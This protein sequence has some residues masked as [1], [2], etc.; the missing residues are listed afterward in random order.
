MTA[1]APAVS[2]STDAPATQSP[3]WADAVIYQIYP[4][5]FADGN[6]DGMGDL[7]GVRS[8]LPYLR[9]LGVDAIWLSPFYVSPQA[10]AGYDVADYRDVDPLFGTLADFDSMLAEAHESGM[11]VIVDLVPNHTSDEH[12]WFKAAK[13]AAIGSPERDRYI[14][15][16]GKGPAGEL[17][18]NNWQSIFGGNAWTRLDDGQWYLHLFDTKQP[19]L[20][21]DN[22]EVRAEMVS[23]LRFWLDR[24][25][26]G[27]RIDVAHGMV[28]AEG[29]PDW[30]EQARMI[31]GGHSDQAADSDSAST[32]TTPPYFDQ[33]GVH[34]IYREWNKVLAQYDGD[35]ML[36]AEAWVEPAE[37]LFRYVRHDEMQQAFN[38]DFL[39]AGWDAAQLTSSITESLAEAGKVGAPSTWVMS[40]HDTVRHTSRFGLED[41]TQFPKGLGSQHEQPDE[42]LG[43][44]RGRAAALVMLGLPGSAYLYQGDELG[45]PEHTTLP[46]GVREDPT[47]ARTSGSEIGRDGCRVPLPWVAEAPG[48]GFGVYDA[49]SAPGAAPWLPQPTSFAGYAADQQ[50][51]VDG[52][53]FELYRSALGLRR[54]HGLGTG[55]LEW[56]PLN[57]PQEGVLSYRNG[58]VLVFANMG[59]ETIDLPNDHRV[60]LASGEASVDGGRLTANASVWLVAAESAS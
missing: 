41:P 37:R 18:P 50:V 38:F 1:P 56:T 52:S 23:V 2:H 8:R 3:W 17:P 30:A 48:F 46:D 54:S 51:G 5:S 13:A 4:R 34:D 10:D 57:S 32:E 22:P 28:K 31:D 60:I 58:E 47:Y 35:R 40:N 19:D 26:D 25:V 45:L 36:V 21:W 42:S 12:D 33:P 14:F 16:D 43:L 49:V 39:L 44:A 9:N 27:F 7:P 6:A 59:A 53:T 20:N 24:G 55:R 11:K 29:L 15:R